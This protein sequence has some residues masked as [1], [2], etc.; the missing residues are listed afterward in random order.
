MA[1]RKATPP[2][3]GNLNMDEIIYVHELSLKNG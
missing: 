3:K 2:L 1:I